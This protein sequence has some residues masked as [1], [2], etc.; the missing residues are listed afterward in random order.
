[1][2]SM[3]TEL[4][5]WTTEEQDLARRVFQRALS[6]EVEA[7]IES[8]RAQSAALRTS[9]DVWRLHDFL[10]VQRHAIEGRLAFRLPGVLFDFA[11]FLRE[12]LVSLEELEGLA[13]DKLAKISAMSRMG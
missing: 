3:D 4:A 9:E 11:G 10:S 12:G 1:M 6:R 7:L 2:R 8:L 13:A 5:G